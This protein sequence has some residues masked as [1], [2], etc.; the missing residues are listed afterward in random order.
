MLIFQKVLIILFYY[1][2]K[3]LLLTLRTEVLFVY[4]FTL[5]PF[6]D[7]YIRMS[8]STIAT[9]IAI[10]VITIFGSI[11]YCFLR[12]RFQRQL[13]AISSAY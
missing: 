3:P 2:S 9:I 6:S 13:T 7:K 8:G 12:R 1:E 10:I 11:L 4:F 5:H